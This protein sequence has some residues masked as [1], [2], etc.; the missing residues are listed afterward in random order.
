M[1]YS[2]NTTGVQGAP[3]LTTDIGTL[4]HDN[5]TDTNAAIFLM[6]QQSVSHIAFLA[7]VRGINGFEVGLYYMNNR[8]QEFAERD[9][10]L[11]SKATRRYGLA[12]DSGGTGHVLWLTETGT[13]FIRVLYWNSN[14][15]PGVEVV[16]DS[17]PCT[18]GCRFVDPQVNIFN[19]DLQAVVRVGSGATYRVVVDINTQAS[20]VEQLPVVLPSRAID[21]FN[22]IDLRSRFALDTN[23]AYHVLVPYKEHVD[24]SAQLLYFSNANNTATITSLFDGDPVTQL[25]AFD[26]AS[27]GGGRIAATWTTN[28][29]RFPNDLPVT[30]FVEYQQD[31]VGFF[32]EVQKIEDLSVIVGNA[33]RESCIAQRIAISGDKVCIIGLHNPTR[34]TDTTTFTISQFLR[35][36]VRPVT[37]YMMPDAAAPG[38]NV[39]VETYAPADRFGSFGPDTLDPRSVGLQLVNPA[40]SSRVVIGPSVVSWDGRLLSTL[41]F[42]RHDA[43]PGEVQ[44]Q[45]EVHGVKSN[46]QSFYVQ[47]PQSLGE[48]KSGTLSGGGTLGSG[49][50]YGVRSPRGV[51]VVDSM[52]LTNG[53]Y[54]A[55]LLDSDPSLDGNQGFL[56]LTILSL[57]PVF[58]DSTAILSVSAPPMV[59]FGDTSMAGPGGGGGGAG[60]K[61][62]G[63]RGYT[64]G[65]KA[66][67]TLTGDVTSGANVGS[68]GS[69]S[70]RYVAGGS[71]NGVSGGVGLPGAAAGGGTGHPFGSS[72]RQGLQG[73]DIRD[74][75]NP[76]ASAHPLYGDRGGYGG[77]T[78]GDTLHNVL[79]GQTDLFSHGGGGGG[80][81]T[82]G[83][84]GQNHN[85]GGRAVGSRVL[86]PLAGGSGGGGAYS[87]RGEAAGGGGGGALALYSYREFYLYG[88]VHAD[89]GVGITEN[90]QDASGGGGGSGGG[91]LM[92]AQGGLFIGPNARLTAIGGEGGRAKPDTFSNYFTSGGHGGDGRIRLDGRF[93]FVDEDRIPSF[94]SPQPG[95]FGPSSGMSGSFQAVAGGV[96]AGS[97]NPGETIRIYLRPEG[98][99]WSYDNPREVV[100]D[101]EGD[102]SIKVSEA[103]VAQGI[104]Y[105]AVLQKVN[106]PSSGRWNAVPSWVMSSAAGNIIG[107]PTVGF[108]TSNADFGCVPYGECDTIA[109]AIRN[110]GTQSDLQIYSGGVVG[111]SAWSVI[112][113]DLLIRIRPGE[114]KTVKVLFCPN[115]TGRMEGRLRMITNLPFGDSIQIVSLKGCGIAG[116][117][118]AN[119]DTINIGDLCP[120]DCRDTVV[121]LSNNGTAPLTVTGIA[122]E[123]ST[124]TVTVLDPDL[125]SPFVLDPGKQRSVRLRVC[126]YGGRGSFFVAFASTTPFPTLKVLFQYNNL[127]PQ[128]RIPDKLDFGVRDLGKNDTCRIVEFQL[129][130]RSAEEVLRLDDL[131]VDGQEYAILAPAPNIEIP[132]LQSALVRVRLCTD[133]VG[134]YKRNLRLALFSGACKQDTIVP[135][136]GRVVESVPNLELQVPDKIDFG[137]VPIGTQSSPH[138][139]VLFNSGG[140]VA[141][142]IW[143]QVNAVAPATV[144][145]V[146]VVVEG[147]NGPFILTGGKR[148]TFTVRMTPAAL[149]LRQAEIVI[150]SSQGIVGT[151][152][153]CV[154]GVEPGI[155]PDTLCL[156]FG[157]IRVGTRVDKELAFTNIG[158]VV[159]E[160]VA[161]NTDQM[162]Q[163]ALVGTSASLP[164]TL[165]PL[166]A[167]DQLVAT[168]RFRPTAPGELTEY[169]KAIT[170]SGDEILVKLVGVGAL[171]RANADVN[172]L[173]YA[174]EDQEKTITITNT[175]SWTL[176]VSDIEINSPSFRLLDVPGPDAIPPSESVSYRIEYVAGG[177]PVNVTATVRHSGTNQVTV[178]LYGQA[179]EGELFELSWQVPDLYGYLDSIVDMP[180]I[181]DI[182]GSLSDDVPFHL[183]LDYEWSLLVP[184]F[185]PVPGKPTITTTA[186][187]VVVQEV[188]PGQVSI[189]GTLLKGT[190]SGTALEIPMRVLLGRTY[191]TV[192]A[193]SGNSDTPLPPGYRAVYD[194][195]SFVGVDCDTTGTIN[196]QG[197]YVIKQNTPNPFRH[198]T[199]IQFEI[200]KR[201]HVRILLYNA[202]G[203][204]IATL[205]DEVLDAGKH[206]L[207]LGP[208]TASAGRYFYEIIS[209]RFRAVRNMLIVE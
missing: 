46:P 9:P 104:L 8:G 72:G 125:T 152:P 146:D 174:C 63:G 194:S 163:V 207:V 14:W 1:L 184:D 2:N 192:V 25:L 135:L 90:S 89:G 7:N 134:E 49:G 124:L 33:R 123:D 128:V 144:G 157:S 45:V 4:H 97:G 183:Q 191:Q 136:V 189:K 23:G 68:G 200:A 17:I 160:L 178:D 101:A 193:I 169:L 107:R 118:N 5:K 171:E 83:A 137:S 31:A 170:K 130:N 29:N 67:Q 100:V 19:T 180:I 3:F 88:E 126:L 196:I 81:G 50:I 199:S 181:L 51:L 84:S 142:D 65:G 113:S 26:I 121:V 176:V 129:E 159:D 79:G 69:R 41:L 20:A 102:W 111:G 47:R 141:E 103:D 105:A 85:N 167:T 96:I 202:S 16:V 27:D 110:T 99:Q 165:R 205:L 93:D 11:L 131:Q 112:P 95:Y 187:G 188:K 13:G 162:S 149:G 109:I 177:E 30:G 139:I 115:D 48:N 209:G 186:A 66:S 168:L 154:K 185:V 120:G 35:H 57:G 143:Y 22:K 76:D 40:D 206:E 116:E 204:L 52:R 92:G 119:R 62:G 98:G 173:D 153:I 201:E 138:D 60:M 148:A 145:E 198:K 127:G 155:I 43:Q 150:T 18:A 15:G 122:S 156:D 80:H 38:M 10:I 106:N 42:I 56:P 36:S 71:L 32:Q 86:V 37:S 91:I 132:P 70:G 55:S 147:I 133:V 87:S 54:H 161:F 59:L 21:P 64:A 61:S 28:R 6:D 12:V 179:C 73:K 39:V 78:G 166:P 108:S 182:D 53:E 151:I 140:G 75:L 114:S 195:G 164:Y 117:L 74:N 203:N 77:G 172:R 34:T 175:G 158:S 24:S 94:D 82:N 208:E 44:M 58:I 190:T 197:R